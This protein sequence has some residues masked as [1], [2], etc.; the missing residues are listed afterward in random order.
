LSA[1]S[2]DSLSKDDPTDY[3]LNWVV[4]H[5]LVRYSFIL[6]GPSKPTR[7]AHGH[8]DRKTDIL[9]LS[10]NRPAGP[11][12]EPFD[13]PAW[14]ITT[15]LSGALMLPCTKAGLEQDCR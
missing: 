10:T 2:S 1:F 13:V 15:L 14:G 12:A 9:R 11:N 5:N 8:Y 4:A 6:R 7:E 3:T